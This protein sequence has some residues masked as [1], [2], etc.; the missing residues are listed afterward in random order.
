MVVVDRHE[1]AAAFQVQHPAKDTP[2]PVEP[3]LVERLLVVSAA[4]VE[5]IRR[6]IDAQDV[7]SARARARQFA[8]APPFARKLHKDQVDPPTPAG[9][10]IVRERRIYRRE[11]NCPIRHSNC[12]FGPV[13][14]VSC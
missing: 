1:M 12:R 2:S 8:F 9:A 4:G 10:R 6:V 14:E 3:H 7:H 5:R 11:S 13:P